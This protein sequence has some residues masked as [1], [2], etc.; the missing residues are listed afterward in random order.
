MIEE[1]KEEGIIIRVIS[2]FVE[3]Q[4]AGIFEMSSDSKGPEGKSYCLQS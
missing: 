4:E 3:G 1:P 2:K